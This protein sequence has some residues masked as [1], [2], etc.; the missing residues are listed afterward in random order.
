MAQSTAL[1]SAEPRYW[2]IAFWPREPERWWDWLSPASC[3]HVSAFS[4]VQDC[5]LWLLVNPHEERTSVYLAD[6]REIDLLRGSI[7][8][9]GG[10][11]IGGY[12]RQ[13]RGTDQRLLQTCSTII[14][15]MI[16]VRGGAWRPIDLL[17]TLQRHDGFTV[18]SKQGDVSQ[19][20]NT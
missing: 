10:V 5:G 1:G 15:R 6:Q 4:Y 2:Y 13:I 3:R 14:A 18:V 19:S 20:E 16:G 7:E 11:L 12:A 17:R 9:G 8:V